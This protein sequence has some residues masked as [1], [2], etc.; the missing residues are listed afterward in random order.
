[1]MIDRLMIAG[2]YDKV[3]TGYRHYSGF[4][5]DHLRVRDVSECEEECGRSSGCYSFSYRYQS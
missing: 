4:Y 1:M 3:K 2:C 5:Q